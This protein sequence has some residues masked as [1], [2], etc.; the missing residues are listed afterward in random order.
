MR[1]QYAAW[2][3]GPEV[4][5]DACCNRLAQHCRSA[6]TATKAVN[7]GDRSG[8][9]TRTAS[10][11]ARHSIFSR[12][13]QRTSKNQDGILPACYDVHRN[14]LKP[15]C[16]FIGMRIARP[17]P[18]CPSA[19]SVDLIILHVARGGGVAHEARMGTLPL[20]GQKVR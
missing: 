11:L 7:R 5:R 4:E 19:G 2:D 14:S 3:I 20:E 13:P 8:V 10:A 9:A 1:L 6:E 17:G 15:E 12:I 18:A 16:I